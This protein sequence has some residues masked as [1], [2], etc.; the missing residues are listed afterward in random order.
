VSRTGIICLW[1]SLR[2]DQLDF[3]LTLTC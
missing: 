1:Q 2:M 3:A